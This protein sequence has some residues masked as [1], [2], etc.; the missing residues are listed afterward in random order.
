M[1]QRNLQNQRNV[2]GPV[3]QTKKS[4]AKAK[5]A[6]KAAATT[7]VGS[8]KPA[9]KKSLFGR[10]N[11]TP[12]ADTKKKPSQQEANTQATAASN[13]AK[14]S[15]NPEYKKW[16]RAWW[17]C[18]GCA[19]GFT[20]LAWCSS[21][22]IPEMWAFVI[23]LVGAYGSIIVAFYIDFKKVKPFRTPNTAVAGG[24]KSN[25]QLKREQEAAAAAA[26]L[27]AARKAAKEQKKR[28]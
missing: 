18:I 17:I 8:S 11:P 21:Y 23:P 22:F 27:E 12:E 14:L 6:K 24:K 3:G 2:E 9:E 5:P 26:E 28:R 15:Q 20:V 4:A 19:L 13:K 16:R 25:K 1:T 10:K 7:Y